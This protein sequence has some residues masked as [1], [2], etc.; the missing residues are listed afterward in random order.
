M[1]SLIKLFKFRVDRNE[2]KEKDVA[3]FLAQLE[4]VRSSLTDD[5]RKTANELVERVRGRP[6][7]GPSGGNDDRHGSRDHRTQ[8]AAATN[9]GA[10][11]PAILGGSFYNPYTFIPF[12]VEPPRRDFPTPLTKDEVEKD[13]FT[14]ILDLDLEL[15]SPLLT[16]SPE[17]ASENNGHK[18]FKVLAIGEDVVVPATGVRGA[19]RTLMTVL[20]NGTLGYLDEE[21]WLCQGRDA[22]LGP[23]VQQTK[24]QVPDSPFLARVVKPGSHQRDG[25]LQLG[26][27]KLINADKLERLVGGYLPRPTAT[28]AGGSLWINDNEDSLSDHPD[29][30]HTWQVKLSG[31][32]IQPRGKREGLFRAEGEPIPV[33]STLWAAYLG[34]HRHSD[35]NELKKGDLVW[36]EPKNPGCSKID[37]ADDIESIQW[38]RWGRR[39][40]RLLDVVAKHHSAQLPDAFNPDGK[41]DE[42]TDLFGQVPREDLADEIDPNWKQKGL[43]GPAKSFAGR[44][45]CGNLVFQAAANKVEKTVLAPL[46]QPH[47]GC[48]AFYRAWAETD[49]GQAADKTSNHNLPLRGFK[50]YRTTREC[51]DNAPWKYSVQGIYDDKGELRPSG[52]K[53]NKTVELLP[54]S[55]GIQGKLRIAVRAL[56]ERELTL[57]LSACA[58][59]WRLG[60]GKPLGLGHCRIRSATLRQFLDEGNLSEPVAINREADSPAE[61]P[62]PYGAEPSQDKQLVARMQLWQASQMQIDQLRYP[63][64]VIENRQ[65][66]RGGHVWFQRHAQPKKSVAEGAVPVGLQTLHLAGELKN[67]A[68]KSRLRA[69]PLPVFDADNPPADVLYGYDLFAGE[70]DEWQEKTR[71]RETHHKKLEPFDP[72]KYARDS[73]ASGGHQG[74]TGETRKKQRRNR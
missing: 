14:G 2:A 66:N 43:P 50:V 7:G 74:Q 12:G 69:Q 31:R 13:R 23:A 9:V 11:A 48:A 5:D 60:G 39:G 64:A 34:R 17:A 67:K 68:G 46:A 53:L 49:P 33:P 20:T 55:C 40:E 57:L 3:A 37:S 44:I 4:K 16:N 8:P 73:D 63:R 19:L 41:V 22:R 38:A 24:G 25:T 28:K 1:H 59:D 32:P 58:V 47:P 62:M 10:G 21:A 29:P 36:L 54:M 6:I 30:S 42:V 26:R 45:R 35:H 61:L 71:N 52:Q 27:T 18:T 15:L 56:T 65:K 70:G 51:G 72:V